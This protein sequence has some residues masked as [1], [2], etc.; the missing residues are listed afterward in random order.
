MPRRVFEIRTEGGGCNT[1]R[2][3]TVLHLA[4]NGVDLLLQ[5]C[6]SKKKKR[7]KLEFFFWMAQFIANLEPA[8][9]NPINCL[10]FFLMAPFIFQPRTGA[11]QSDQLLFATIDLAVQSFPL[12]QF[13]IFRFR[14]STFFLHR[15]FDQTAAFLSSWIGFFLK[16]IGINC[17]KPLNR[18]TFNWLASSIKRFKMASNCGIIGKSSVK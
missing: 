5:F 6:H 18:L 3:N 8:L 13:A 1:I 4:F 7:L 2:I 17:A 10:S 12:I 16:I 9:A 15:R 14:Q 11:G